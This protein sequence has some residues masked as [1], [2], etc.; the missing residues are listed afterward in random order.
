[1]GLEDPN[2]PSEAPDGLTYSDLE[3]AETLASNL[4]SQAQPLLVPPAQAAA[5]DSVREAMQSFALAP[6]SEPQVTTPTS[7]QVHPITQG[8]QGFGPERNG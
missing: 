1:M 2:P 8:R 6:T 3:K 7:L 4:E 5:V